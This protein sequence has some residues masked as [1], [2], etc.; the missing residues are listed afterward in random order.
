MAFGFPVNPLQG[1]K[2]IECF[3][4]YHLS[5]HLNQSKLYSDSDQSG[6]YCFDH[7]VGHTGLPFGDPIGAPNKIEAKLTSFVLIINFN[8]LTNE[9]ETLQN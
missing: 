9:F 5:L 8:T 7:Q 3:T 1:I 4:F 2:A 6:F